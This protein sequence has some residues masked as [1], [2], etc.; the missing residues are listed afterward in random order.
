MLHYAS[1]SRRR[2]SAENLPLPSPATWGYLAIPPW[3]GATENQPKDGDAF[4]LGSK[5]RY[6]SY[7]GG[8]KTV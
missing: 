6:G 2:H 4:R 7:L 5:G 8:S 1:V 3:V